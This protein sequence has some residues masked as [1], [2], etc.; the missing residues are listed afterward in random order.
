MRIRSPFFFSF[1]SPLGRTLAQATGKPPPSLFPPPLSTRILRMYAC[2]VAG[3]GGWGEGFAVN[4]TVYVRDSLR[5]RAQRLGCSMRPP[6]PG[7]SVVGELPGSKVPDGRIYDDG[8]GGIRERE[9]KER[10]GKERKGKER[11][12]TVS[13]RHRKLVVCPIFNF[14]YDWLLNEKRRDGIID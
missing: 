7:R 6:R 12:G 13:Y 8:A 10:R 5:L 2:C 11:N 14:R 9:G 3:L 1:F 4:G